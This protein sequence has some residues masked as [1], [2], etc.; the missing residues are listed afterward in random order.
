MVLLKNNSVVHLIFVQFLAVIALTCTAQKQGNVWYFGD[1]A[2]IDFNT[3]PP[4]VLYDGQTEFIGCSACH[5]EGSSVISDST[6]KLLFYCNGSTI[7]NRNHEI[8]PNGDSLMS[9]ASATQGSIIIPKPGSSELFYVFTVDAFF[10]DDL[11]YGFRYSLVNMCLDGGLGDVDTTEKNVFLKDYVTE[12]LTAVRHANGIDYWVVVHKFGSDQFLAYLISSTGISAP[13]TTSIGSSHMGSLGTSIG[14][15]KVSPDGSRIALVNAQASVNIAEVFDFDNA[16]GIVSNCISVQTDVT[17]GYYGVSFSPD[18]S[19]L[20]LACTL[21]GNG[22]YQFDL[23]AGSPAAIL[24]SKTQIAGFYNYLGLQLANNGKIYSAR[25]PFGFHDYIGVINYPDNAGLLCD[26]QDSAIFLDGNSASYGFPNFV[27]SYDY[28]I[29]TNPC[30][31]LELDEPT[32]KIT[33]YPNPA[34]D[35][36][37]ISIQGIGDFFMVTLFGS[38]AKVCHQ[39]TYQNTNHF[40]IPLTDY[41]SGIYYLRITTET[42]SFPTQKIFVQHN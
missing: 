31:Q 4:T 2:G 1:H 37:Q 25:S 30:P 7:W 11:I 13:V 12:K 16:S 17:W 42:A 10:I 23:G 3:E 15:M 9:N 18:N 39:K 20:Y 36:L 29:T 22:I 40:S 8:M 24:A 35:E 14:Q 26:Y 6:G 41:P 21:N 19:K 34:S 33:N 38:S 27:D 28:D 32:Y 5:S